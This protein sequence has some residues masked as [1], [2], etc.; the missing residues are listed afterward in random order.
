MNDVACRYCNSPDFQGVS[1]IVGIG[2]PL[3]Q[4]HA[5]A[6]LPGMIFPN[7]DMPPP[8][9]FQLSDSNP[10][11]QVLFYSCCEMMPLLCVLLYIAAPVTLSG[12]IDA[13]ASCSSAARPLL[14][15]LT[16][17]TSPISARFHSPPH[18]PALSCSLYAPDSW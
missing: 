15:F 16:P 14:V 3:P 1:G 18:T 2:L 13:V 6:D 8:L 10:G 9:H 11:L 5:P 4:M 12:S 17:L 7:T